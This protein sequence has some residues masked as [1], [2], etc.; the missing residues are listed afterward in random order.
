[1]EELR[2]DPD[3]CVG[4]KLVTDSMFAE[5]L[6]IQRAL[7]IRQLDEEPN[8]SFARRTR[9]VRGGLDQVEHAVLAAEDVVYGLVLILG[10]A[11]IPAWI[12]QNVPQD[13]NDLDPAVR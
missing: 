8:D 13:M 1:M 11:V 10:A 7:R 4:L 5:P 3:Y 12:A 9:H 6:I 2:I